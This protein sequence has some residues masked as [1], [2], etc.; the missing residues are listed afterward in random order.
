MSEAIT[1]LNGGE[2]LGFCGIVLGLVA[3]LGG[4]AIGFATLVA[5][6]K[7]RVQL[8]EMEATLK[9]EMIQRG[10]SAGEIK[11]IL[12]AKMGGSKMSLTELLGNCRAA[13]QGVGTAG[14][15][16]TVS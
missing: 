3:L 7:R 14:R 5:I 2:I 9:M 6:Y 1:R 13:G 8:D 16:Q 4:L 10:M 11:Q 15:T 12:E